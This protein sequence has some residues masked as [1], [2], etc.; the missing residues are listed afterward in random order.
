MKPVLPVLML[1]A[2]LVPACAVELITYCKTH[3]DWLRQLLT[4]DFVVPSRDI[5]QILR[6]A[7]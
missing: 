4:S 7:P 1:L 5:E 3:P 2:S 6:V